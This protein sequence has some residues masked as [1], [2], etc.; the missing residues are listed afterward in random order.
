VTGASP[1]P[2][3]AVVTDDLDAVRVVRHAA[4]LA[5]AGKRPLLLLVPLVGA[6]RSFDPALHHAAHRHRDRDAEATLGRVAPVLGRHRGPV[7][8]RVV[9]Y[10][11]GRTRGAGLEAVLRAAACADADVLVAA[12]RWA[13]RSTARGLVLLCPETGLPASGQLE[14]AGR[15]SPPGE[16][17]PRCAQPAARST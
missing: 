16:H 5:T 10:R 13:G 6:G 2:V 15:V 4:R 8:A 1:R 14:S 7:S 17:T 9:T 11:P 12:A 3:A